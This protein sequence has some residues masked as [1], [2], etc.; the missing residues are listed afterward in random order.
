MQEDQLESIHSLLR[1]NDCAYLSSALRKHMD[2]R[3]NQIV[4]LE[5]WKDAALEHIRVNQPD[6]LDSMWEIANKSADGALGRRL[7]ANG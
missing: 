4:H 1:D 7:K 3:E 2:Q 5:A 6:R